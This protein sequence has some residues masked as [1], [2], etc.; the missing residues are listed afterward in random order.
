LIDVTKLQRGNIW[1]VPFLP[2]DNAKVSP[3]QGRVPRGICWDAAIAEA[4]NGP[5][6]HE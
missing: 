4:T 2:D 3:Q 1:R 6:W 5:T